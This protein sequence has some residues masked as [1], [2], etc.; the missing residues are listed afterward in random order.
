MTRADRILIAVLACAAL[1]AWPWV[2]SA[3]V[4]SGEAV[5]EA[6]AG[7][8]TI[9]LA[10]DAI[11]QVAGARGTVVVE[12][13]DGSVRV[14]ESDCPDQVCVRTGAVSAPGSVIACVPNGVVVRVGGGGS[15]GL[16]ARVR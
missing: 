7:R 6:P 1:L 9:A 5:I 8:T 10:D 13:A 2:A 14:L 3:G 15:D 12:V 4:A 16:D 11:Y